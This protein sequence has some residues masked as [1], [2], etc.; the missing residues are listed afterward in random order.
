MLGDPGAGEQDGQRPSMFRM[1]ERKRKTMGEEQKRR[2]PQLRRLWCLLAFMVTLVLGTAGCAAEDRD[3]RTDPVLAGAAYTERETVDRETE[4]LGVQQNYGEAQAEGADGESEGERDGADRLEQGPDG[5]AEE[6]KPEEAKLPSGRMN[7][8][9]MDVGQADCILIEADGAAMLVDAGKNEDG[10]QIV[11]YLKEQGIARLEYVIGT[12]PHEDHIGG[13][14]DVLRNFEVGTVILPAKVHTTQ[15]YMDVLQAVEDCG[16]AVT[17]AVRG[18]TFGLGE[19]S[20]TILSPPAG[21]DYGDELNN[22]S[23]AIRLTYGQ[24]S[25]VLTGDAEEA[26]EADILASGLELKAD[27]VKAGHHGSKT[28]NSPAFLQAVAPSYAVISCGMGNSYGHPD[29]EILEE[30]Q[31]LGTAVFRTDEQGTVVAQSDG[32]QIAWNVSPSTTMRPGETETAAEEVPEE[33]L[34]EILEEIP[35]VTIEE[36][37]EQPVSAEPLEEVVV[38][39]TK[40]GEKYHS[41][42]CR[43]LKKSD[44]EVTLAEAKARGLE[45]CSVCAPPQ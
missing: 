24:N 17:Q 36:P 10:G 26:A 27:V 43:Y 11:E 38:H 39:I 4:Y 34:E 5:S 21:S 14:D 42:G 12:H 19:A 32:Q 41:G 29:L 45:P 33:I 22:W 8:H 35:E 40:T 23:V 2:S 3:Q 16:L 30:F 7:V 31:A 15:T 1:E 9:F 6:E 37:A 13:M 44:I 25:F 28:S 20:F 18:D